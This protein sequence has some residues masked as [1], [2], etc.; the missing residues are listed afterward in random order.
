LNSIFEE[1]KNTTENYWFQF[2]SW[3]IYY[4]S[5]PKKKN[6]P[7]TLKKNRHHESKIKTMNLC[8][9]WRARYRIV[10]HGSLARQR[11]QSTVT[12]ARRSRPIVVNVSASLDPSS[13]QDLNLV[14]HLAPIFSFARMDTFFSNFDSYID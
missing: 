10:L 6:V 2:S 5:M 12:R 1:R 13:V 7:L 8:R 9:W 11:R 14:N 3:D 4:K